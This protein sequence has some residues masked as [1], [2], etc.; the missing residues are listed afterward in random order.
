MIRSPK[1]LSFHSFLVATSLAFLWAVPP[2]HAVVLN[3]GDNLALPG[4]TAV[5][6]PQLAGTALVDELVPFSFNTANG[7]ITGNVQQTVLRSS[8]DNTLDF[9]WRVFNDANS[10]A[11]IGSL[12]VGNFVAPVYNANWRIDGLGDVGP[13]HAHRFS[14]DDTFVNFLFDAP[15]AGPPGLLPGQSSKYFFF[16]TTATSYNKTA[17]YDLTGTAGNS[18]ISLSFPTYTPGVPE[19][20]SV[21]LVTTGLAILLV[22]RRWHLRGG[23]HV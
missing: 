2:V 1:P 22:G 18:G 15:S 13:A 6:E 8:V 19:P 3:P 11:P 7:L 14:P 20:A 21:L 10:A 12:R 9:Y 4:T 16:D 5:A 23:R 17:S